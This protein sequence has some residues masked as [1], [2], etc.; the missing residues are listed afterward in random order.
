M[1]FNAQHSYS[2]CHFVCDFTSVNLAKEVKRGNEV[3]GDGL[4]VN[5][6]LDKLATD[7]L[8]FKL[9]SP[10]ITQNKALSPPAKNTYPFSSLSDVRRTNRADSR[11]NGNSDFSGTHME[12]QKETTDEDK[13]K[14]EECAMVFQV[15]KQLLIAGGIGLAIA[16][17]GA[18]M[19]SEFG[20]QI[21]LFSKVPGSF[22]FINWEYYCYR[23][24]RSFLL[25]FSQ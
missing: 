9:E 24:L 16:F 4:Y 2:N 21:P 20:L 22:L 15:W 17:F 5:D 1:Q 3:S 8:D 13:T 7:T 6:V 14:D 19:L 10:A 25:G 11:A 12:D 18:S 23:P